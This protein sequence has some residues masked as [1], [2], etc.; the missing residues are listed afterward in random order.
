[1]LTCTHSARCCSPRAHPAPASSDSATADNR[2]SSATSGPG[3]G[4]GAG[5]SEAAWRVGKRLATG[6]A[7]RELQ[8]PPKKAEMPNQRQ[9]TSSHSHGQQV[10]NSNV[11]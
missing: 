7:A 4:F 1:M 2:L 10:A 11:K 8:A 9:Q 6:P 3:A 5:A